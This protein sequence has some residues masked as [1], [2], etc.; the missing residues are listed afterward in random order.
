MF[1]IGE[2]QGWGIFAATNGAAGPWT[3]VDKLIPRYNFTDPPN[4]HLPDNTG[5]AVSADGSKMFTVDLGI[6]AFDAAAVGSLFVWYRDG[7]GNFSSSSPYC[8]LD[9]NLTT[10]GYIAIDDDGS[11]L[12]PESGRS[13]GGVISRFA[14]PFPASGTANGE[15]CGYDFATQKSDFIADVFS[16]T[17]ISIVRRDSLLGGKWLVGGPVPGMIHEYDADGN[18]VR[19][20]TVLQ[21]P[22]VAGMAVDPETNDLYVANLGLIPDP[23]ALFTTGPMTGTL[24]RIPFD[25]VTDTPLA[26]ILIQPLLDYPEGMGIYGSIE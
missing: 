26:P 22:G 1:P 3:L 11:V 20:I 23:E 24:W 18:F 13:S 6:G 17:P 7:A 12:L 10:A 19:P 21:G 5:C 4:T 2:K 9:D 25:P 16:F 14:P 15:G 8:I